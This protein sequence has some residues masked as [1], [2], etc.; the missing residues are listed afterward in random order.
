MSWMP[1]L[2]HIRLAPFQFIAIR[3]TYLDPGW[4]DRITR[5]TVE[6]H[7]EEAYRSGN[8][9]FKYP[10]FAAWN[11]LTMLVKDRGMLTLTCTEKSGC[12]EFCEF[13]FLASGSNGRIVE[14]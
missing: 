1:C 3:C 5:R 11:W 8:I 6:N 13:L 9:R 12:T 7:G 4:C 10:F 14:S 2:Y